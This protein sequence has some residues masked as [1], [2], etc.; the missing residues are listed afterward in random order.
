MKVISLGE[1]QENG[2][3]GSE[4]HTQ[5]QPLKISLSMKYCSQVGDDGV[6]DAALTFNHTI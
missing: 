1:P 3:G 2:P 4:E 5:Q 6:V